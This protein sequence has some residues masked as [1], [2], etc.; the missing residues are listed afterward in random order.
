[1]PLPL[2][3]KTL[4]ARYDAGHLYE[5]T[6]FWGHSL[7]V[8]GGINKSCFS[9]WFPLPFEI[10]GQHYP[11]AEHWM[12]AEKARLFNDSLMLEEIL[13]SSDPGTAKALEQSILEQRGLPS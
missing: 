8:D 4:Q 12:M 10:D 2:D 11:T 6:F 7:P 3:L 5:F 1:M 13:V 9:Q